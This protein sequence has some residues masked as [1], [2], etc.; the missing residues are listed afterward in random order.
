MLRLFVQI[1]EAQSASD[2]DGF[3]ERVNTVIVNP[4]IIL[5][6]AIA[7]MLFFAGLLRFFFQRD[8]SS[9]EAKKGRRHMLWGIIGMFIM[10]SVFGIMAAIKNTL[11]V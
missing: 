2:I 9:D 11:G 10:M 5:F 8:Q 1:A 3:I 4:L 7:F 6:F